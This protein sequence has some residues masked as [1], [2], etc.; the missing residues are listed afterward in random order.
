MNVTAKKCRNASATREAILMAAK[1]HF[2]RDSYDQA[3]IRAIAADAGIDPAMICRY[4]GSKRGLFAEVLDDIGEDPMKFFAGE[5]SSF[6]KRVAALMLEPEKH[7]PEC[8]AFI[9][10][11]TRSSG[12]DEARSTLKQHINKQFIRPFSD[13]LGDR[14]AEAKSWRILSIL[15]GLTITDDIRPLC[16]ADASTLARLLQ[17]VLDT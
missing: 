2:S 7:F 1:L 11:V 3:G 12:S 16:K 10:L 9:N 4:F 5:R 17:S 14:D 6:G 13:W 15:M 8:H